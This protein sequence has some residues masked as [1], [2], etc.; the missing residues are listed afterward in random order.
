MSLSDNP[1]YCVNYNKLKAQ[2]H[3]SNL[4]KLECLYLE[5]WNKIQAYKFRCNS[6][7]TSLQCT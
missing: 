7:I 3:R 5:K 4:C 6:S 2:L 1:M